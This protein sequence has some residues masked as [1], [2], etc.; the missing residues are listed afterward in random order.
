MSVALVRLVD[1]ELADD[2]AVGGVELEDPEARDVVERRLYCSA[3]SRPR[4]TL[5]VRGMEERGCRGSARTPSSSCPLLDDRRMR[6]TSLEE[7]LETLFSC[8]PPTPELAHDVARRAAVRHERDRSQFARPDPS[9]A[10]H[11]YRTSAVKTP[12]THLFARSTTLTCPSVRA[13]P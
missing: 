5:N 10:S 4:G 11:R 7:A 2:V 3:S 13:P 12:A 8:S 9:S 1:V 6:P